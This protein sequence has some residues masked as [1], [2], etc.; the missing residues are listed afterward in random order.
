MGILGLIGKLKLE[1]VTKQLSYKVVQSQN[2]F[3]TFQIVAYFLETIESVVYSILRAHNDKVYAALDLVDKPTLE[4]I[5][6]TTALNTRYY[7]CRYGF[8]V[9]DVTLS[10]FVNISLMVMIS[11]HTRLTN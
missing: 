4:Q 7:R 1:S 11:K 6:E 8:Q 5:D 9:F 10:F 2:W 3:L